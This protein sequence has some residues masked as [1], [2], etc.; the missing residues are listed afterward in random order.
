MRELLALDITEAELDA[1]GIQSREWA[2]VGL[3]G[4]DIYAEP[5]GL[6]AGYKWPQ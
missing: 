3:T 6:L 4:N 1:I 2:L 5:R